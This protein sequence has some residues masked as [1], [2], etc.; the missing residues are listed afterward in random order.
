M[1]K[2]LLFLLISNFYFAQWSISTA[3]RNALT[4]LFSS[5]DGANWSTV[6]DLEKDPKNWYGIKVKNGNVTEINL[7]G[8]A[9]KGNF[10]NQFSVFPKLEK[11]D[12][13]NNQLS[14][15]VG[16]S[17]S[18]VTNLTRLDLSN[19]RLEGDPSA[20]LT[21]LINLKELSIG[22]N[23]FS[24]ATIGT[25][26]TSFPN[27]SVLNIANLNLTSVPTQISSLTKLEIL[28]LSSNPITNFSALQ[29]RTLLKE[30]N[31]SSTSIS[32]IPSQI[33]SLVNLKTLDLSNNTLMGNYSSPL[34][35]LHSLEWLSLE[36]TGI[37]TIPNEVLQLQKLIHLNLGRNKIS[38]GLS[39]LVSLSDLQQLF[40]NHN[41]LSGNFPS[42]LLQLDRLQMLSLVSNNLTGNLPSNLPS[43]TFIDNNKFTQSNIASFLQLE[44]KV[45][46]FTYSPQRYDTETTVGAP[47]GTSTTLS[48]SLTGSD[49]TFSWYKNLDEKL[50]VNTENLYI[51]DIENSDY[52]KYTA[53]AYFLKA[54]PKYVMEVSFW[55]EPITLEN[56]LSTVELNKKLTVFP[57]P[58]SDYINI[59]TENLKFEKA[60]IY[61]LSGK[62]ILE[63]SST[64]I[65]VR[66]LPSSVYIITLKTDQGEKTIKWIKK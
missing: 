40:L 5:T 44:N 7:R 34:T 30:L 26:I 18:S 53:E 43:L 16:T 45:A 61:D 15:E 65:D 6:W 11:L 21:S 39:S 17:L 47:L 62:M 2:L 27:L 60:F 14:G 32:V 55:R 4:Q 24:I 36:N 20:I 54:Y 35:S 63:T 42:E 13:S 12:L 19:N 10:P 31:L 66:N 41:S 56:G 52:G 22:T 49:Y 33:S 48:Q 50:N 46:D 59:R 3:E 9:L 38:G 25:L 29:N 58:T 28:D 64:K 57:N 23:N 8:N 51:T 37:S 1:K